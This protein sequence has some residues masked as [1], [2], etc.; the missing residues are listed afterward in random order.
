MND[1]SVEARRWRDQA[2]DDLEYA[3]YSAKGGFHAQACFVSQQVAE[4]ALKAI[5]YGRG[6][7]AVLGHSVVALVDALHPPSPEL[8]ALRPQAV[9]LDLFY[10]PTRYPNGLVSGTPS[11][12]FGPEQSAHAIT[13]AEAILAAVDKVLGFGHG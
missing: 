12:A 4:K 10:I 6:A 11:G 5:H 3:R 13:A 2:N 8:A 9:D 7:R 1:P